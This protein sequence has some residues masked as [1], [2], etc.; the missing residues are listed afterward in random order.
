MIEKGTYAAFAD[1]H[2]LGAPLVAN[3]ALE[4]KEPGYV[5]SQSHQSAVWSIVTAPTRQRQ[6]NQ[7]QQEAAEEVLAAGNLILP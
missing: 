7:R 2:Q 5:R 4:F 1:A 6:K 3:G